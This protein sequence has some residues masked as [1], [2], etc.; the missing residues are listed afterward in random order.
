MTRIRMALALTTLALA[1]T[2]GLAGWGAAP[3]PATLS[4]IKILTCRPY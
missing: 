4:I 1:G 3:G 2:L